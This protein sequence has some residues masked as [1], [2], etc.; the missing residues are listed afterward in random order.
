M[1]KSCTGILV[2]LMGLCSFSSG[3]LLQVAKLRTQLSTPVVGSGGLDLA[4][5]AKLI[6]D[7]RAVDAEGDLTGID[8][9]V[10]DEAFLQESVAM[11]R[12][13]A[14]VCTAWI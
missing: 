6:A 4:K 1:V 13:Q 8:V 10:A 11:V 12:Q 3:P 2:F 7:V 9:V 5:S 14:E